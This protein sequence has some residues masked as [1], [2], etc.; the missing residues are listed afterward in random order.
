[1]R[2]H[3]FLKQYKYQTSIDAFHELKPKPV[4]GNEA[5]E[6]GRTLQMFLLWSR[7]RSNI[8]HTQ[9]HPQRSQNT[10]EKKHPVRGT[11]KRHYAQHQKMTILRCQGVMNSTF[12]YRYWTLFRKVRW[13]WPGR[14]KWRG[15]YTTRFTIWSCETL[16]ISSSSL[17]SVTDCPAQW[18]IICV[19]GFLAFLNWFCHG[20]YLNT[21]VRKW[22]NNARKYPL[23]T[24][25][26]SIRLF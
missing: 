10:D 22:L 5:E 3:R 20:R 17:C 7:T 11:P 15:K 13:G 1:M 12:S 19:L 6:E 18:T 21:C 25:F 9:N 16:V 8:H 24:P 14:P 23:L 2:E 4:S 26:N